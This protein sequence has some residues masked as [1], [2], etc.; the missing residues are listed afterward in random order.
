MTKE[1]RKERAR[2]RTQK[3]REDNKEKIKES[4]KLYREMNKEKISKYRKDN[5]E[6]IKDDRE[7]N[8]EYYKTY[9]ENNKTKSKEYQKQYRINNSEKLKKYIQDKRKNNPT[10]RTI[11]NIRDRVR[12]AV[13]YYGDISKQKSTLKMLGCNRETLMR[14]LQTSGERYDL[15]FNIYDYDTSMYHIDHIKTFSDVSKG[16]YTLEEVCHYTNLQILPAEINLS[17]SGTSWIL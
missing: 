4:S 15:K 12:K 10:F 16:V 2:L 7:N 11:R 1:E 13:R 14:H 8:K 9:R 3:Y 6:K 17:K 5:A